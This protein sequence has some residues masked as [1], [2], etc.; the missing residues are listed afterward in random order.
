MERENK[1]IYN[2]WQARYARMNR[3][4]IMSA[5]VL[6]MLFLIY[7]LVKFK[8]QDI[9]GTT[10][11]ANVGLVLF[12]LFGD[13]FIYFRRKDSFRLKTVVGIEIGIVFLTV[14]LQT[15]ATFIYYVLL[16]MLILQVPYY[17]IKVYFKFLV[18]Y[19]ILYS[20][21]LGVRLKQDIVTI[22]A[23]DFCRNVC[24]YLMFIVA[25]AVGNVSKIFSDHALGYAKEQAN[26]QQEILDNI[27]DISRT[28]HQETDKSTELVNSLV[29]ATQAV[30]NSMG[31]ITAASVTTAHSIE[32][33]NSMT[34]NIQ[35][36]IE[37]AN[38]RSKMMVQIAT[39][40][41]ESIHENMQ[42]MENLKQQSEQIAETNQEVTEAM[43]R[44]QDKTKEV[45]EIA[46]M[47]LNI[48]SQTN[49]LALN[50]SIESARAGEAG[51]GFA[52][53]A[54][55][56]RQLAE[57]TKSST[58]E[59]TRITNELNKNTTEIVGSVESS[60]DATKNQNE[61]ILLAADSFGKLNA[62]MV[63]LISGIS[64]M[65]E[66][67]SGLSD[68]NNRIVANIGQL[69][70]ATQE[71]NA[72]AQEVQAMSEQNLDYAEDVKGAIHLIS[73]TTNSM[74]KYL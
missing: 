13:I 7:L 65:D 29:T 54:E 57:Q 63:D 22:G 35:S 21:L 24:V 72:S 2:D 23:D 33:Q 5:C 10:V 55:Q 25:Y 30:T 69:S 44:L 6:W 26:R 34:Q 68:A 74:S 73:D 3:A 61:K 70:A 51:R 4:F 1:Y 18:G 48:S 19:S 53:V 8:D 60:V 67:I 31:E 56:I 15:D 46:A 37:E 40:S 38:Q 50:A 17:D 49:L 62:N 42:I 71:I 20:I 47:I 12:F 66:Q 43:G 64:E 27:I 39:E 45:E 52:V 41:N 32:D 14:G 59:I 16:G 11:Y 9:A 36:A 28:V 58:E